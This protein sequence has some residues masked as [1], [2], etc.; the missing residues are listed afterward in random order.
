LLR[1]DTG[2]Q[3]V[4]TIA[5]ETQDILQPCLVVTYETAVVAIYELNIEEKN[6]AGGVIGSEEEKTKSNPPSTLTVSVGSEFLL[7]VSD[8]RDIQISSKASAVAL[9]RSSRQLILAVAEANGII[10]F[11]ALNGTM[12]RQIQTNA[13]IAAMETNRNLLAFSDGT[14]VIISSMTRAQGSVFHSCPGSSA[15][16]SS[17]A[18]DAVHPEIMYAGTERGEVLVYIVNAGASSDSQACRLLSRHTVTSSR[19]VQT[20]LALAVTKRYVI[21][22][23]PHDIAVFNVSKSQKTGVSLSQLCTSH[24][25]IIFVSGEPRDQALS[26]VVAF[27]EG[28]IGSTLAFVTAGAGDQAKLILFHSL[29]PD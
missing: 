14:R 7:T 6:A 21:A 27:S 1:I 13:S 29:L 16:I 24:Q 4:K 3:G 25:Y 17:I 15:K 2:R 22:T 5:L 20:P 28:V 12:L 11:F 10:D 18:F 23:G 26:P 9:A 8:H 19:R